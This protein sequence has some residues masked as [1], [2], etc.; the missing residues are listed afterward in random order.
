MIYEN[1]AC[2]KIAD[3]IEE[4]FLGTKGEDKNVANESQ[5]IFYYGVP[6]NTGIRHSG[7]VRV[8]LNFGEIKCVKLYSRYYS[9]RPLVWLLVFGLKQDMN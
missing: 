7:I 8:I 5:Y 2:E 3:C 6:F 1:L 9:A 4:M